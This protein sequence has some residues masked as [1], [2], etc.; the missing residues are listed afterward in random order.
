MLLFFIIIRF[1]IYQRQI[2]TY[3][4]ILHDAVFKE[5][6]IWIRLVALISLFVIGSINIDSFPIFLS[7]KNNS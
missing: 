4:D 1:A 7:G 3:R 6:A 2:S 5:K